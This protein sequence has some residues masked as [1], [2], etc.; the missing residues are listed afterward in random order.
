MLP[1]YFPYHYA[2]LARDLAGC[3]SKSPEGLKMAYGKLVRDRPILPLQQLMAVLPPLSAHCVPA[4]AR[5]LM[6]EADSE[7]AAQYPMA[8]DLDP[9]GKPAG[10]RWLWVALLPFCDMD[11]LIRVFNKRVLPTLDDD[12]RR[13]N[14]NGPAELVT[15]R[16]LAP[17]V[18]DKWHDLPP[19]SPVPGSVKASGDPG[20]LSFACSR[21]CYSPPELP[22]NAPPVRRGYEAPE[23]A[24]PAL[25]N[26]ANACTKQPRYPAG[27]DAVDR[28]LRQLGDHA[29]RSRGP[30]R[31]PCRYFA[32]GHCDKGDACGFLHV[33][34]PPP[35]ANADAKQKGAKG[36]KQHQTPKLLT[37]PKPPL[38]S[39]ARVFVPTQVRP[40]AP[41]NKAPPNKAPPNKAPPKAPP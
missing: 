20:A 4:A 37:R 35:Q 40:K 11:A 39:S 26:Y 13:R 38:S 5:R 33:P 34:N 3:V 18:P 14:R 17:L 22:G 16:K 9:N 6:T 25:E 24:L 36:Q 31:V 23:D 10:L 30:P 41:P 1:R 12:E 2:P 21:V 28:A 15:A 8:F 29:A 32:K 7:L 27:L 19:D